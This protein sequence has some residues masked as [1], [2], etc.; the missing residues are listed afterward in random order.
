MKSPSAARSLA[1][2]PPRDSATSAPHL[3]EFTFAGFR[4]LEARHA[5]GQRLG[6]HA[7]DRATLLISLG[8]EFEERIEGSSIAV[9]C[10]DV[11]WKPGGATHENH[12]PRGARSFVIEFYR[13]FWS[14]RDEHLRRDPWAGQGLP[15]AILL[16]LR[17]RVFS[18][19]D[20]LGV[21]LDEL[22]TRSLDQIRSAKAEAL[23][24]PERMARVRDRLWS[25]VAAPP[26][27][28]E[29]AADVELHPSHLCRL[30]RRQFGCSMGEYV[31]RVRI[32]RALDLLRRQPRSS[33]SDIA[34]G[35]GYADQS[36]FTRDFRRL[37]GVPPGR[38]RSTLLPAGRKDRSIR[39]D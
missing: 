22:L 15:A 9:Q 13:D 39:Q 38:Y 17:D 24:A 12:Y 16:A 35:L 8:P 20:P 1:N 14:D 26:R 25:T 6:A 33:L 11:V 29:L 32:R 4:M 34:F 28:A 37:V 36:H 7:H 30:F 27:L 10:L 3:R 2:N 23:P 21:E 5:P 19:S 18:S 31:R